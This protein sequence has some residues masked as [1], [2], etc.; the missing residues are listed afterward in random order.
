MTK[1]KFKTALLRGQGRCILAVK[2]NPKKYRDLVMWA[3]GNN[4]SFDTQCEGSRAWYVHELVSFYPDTMPFVEV[5][6]KGL[7]K[8]RSDGSWRIL[9]LSE[10]LSHFVLD[11]C[12]I[13]KVALE[14]KYQQLYDSLMA[15]KRPKNGVNHERD[16]FTMLCLIMAEDEASF[17]KIAEDIGR[18]YRCR[19]FYD[20]YDFDW[21]YDCKGKKYLSALKKAATTSKNIACYLEKQRECEREWEE[22]RK[23]SNTLKKKGIALSRWLALKANKET[24]LQYAYN[25]LAQD[26]L[27]KRAEALEA[28]C[29]CPYPEDP[30]PIIEDTESEC[31]KLQDAAWR[32]LGK[33]RHP[34]VREFAFSKIDSDLVNVLPLFVKNYLSKDADLLEQLVRSVPVDHDDSSGWHGVQLDVLGMEDDGIKAPPTLLRYIYESTFCSCCREHALLQMGKRR[35][36][37]DD[38]LQ[39]CLYDSNDEIRTYA[40]ECLKRQFRKQNSHNKEKI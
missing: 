29:W 30:S 25:Y 28:F 24:V 33:I 40:S 6:V 35:M 13:A 7:E 27:E 23:N 34:H 15:R 9:Y 10:L 32:A 14:N 38:I 5:A 12:E 3:C 11:G 8:S 39:E 36:L 2:D 19:P 1:K 16:D 17:I 20:G 26:D 4:L 21:V 18:L 22:S 37:T 31:E